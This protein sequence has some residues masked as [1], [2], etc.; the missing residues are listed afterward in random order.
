MHTAHQRRLDNP[1]FPPNMTISSLRLALLAGLALP[2]GLATASL[3]QD[4]PPA[5]PAGDAAGMHHEH[6]RDPAER[7][8]HMAEHLSTVLQLQPS[9]QGALAAFLDA[10]KPSGDMKAHMEHADGDEAHLPAPERMDHMLAHIDAMR[11]H[12]A[13]ATAA[14]KAFYAQLTPSQQKAFDDLAPMVMM[15]HMGGH[16]E[17]HHD[18]DGDMMGHHHD[19]DGAD[20]PMGPGG[21]PPG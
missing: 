17:H 15:H 18:G 13:T 19:G 10:M 2:L 3:A 1:E 16:G 4:A 8:A 12:L 20:H 11:A 21:Q 5:P 7:R 9:Q 14:T 6:M